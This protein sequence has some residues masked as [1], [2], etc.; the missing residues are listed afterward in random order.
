MPL[1]VSP[2]L[3]DLV[4]RR[5]IAELRQALVHRHVIA[6]GGLYKFEILMN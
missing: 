3:V 2:V 5:Q 6:K 1:H 4:L